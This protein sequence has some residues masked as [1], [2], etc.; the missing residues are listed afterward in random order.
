MDLFLRF[1]PFETKVQGLKHLQTKVNIHKYSETS[2]QTLTNT[3]FHLLQAR[4]LIRPLICVRPWEEGRKWPMREK[5]ENNLNKS[6]K[7]EDK[8]SQAYLSFGARKKMFHVNVHKL[9]KHSSKCFDVP[10]SLLG[11]VNFGAFCQRSS[12]FCV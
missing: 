1:S 9:P 2:F 4:D 11:Y 10:S 7:D 6:W 3:D 5:Q 8:T 12:A